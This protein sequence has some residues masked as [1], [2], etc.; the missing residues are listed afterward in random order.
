MLDIVYYIIYN[1]V[2]NGKVYTKGDRSKWKN[3]QYLPVRTITV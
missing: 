3:K 2:N 1:K